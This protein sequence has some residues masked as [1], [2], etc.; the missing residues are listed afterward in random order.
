MDSIEQRYLGA[1]IEEVV[2]IPKTENENKYN[3]RNW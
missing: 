1:S 2:G 3:K